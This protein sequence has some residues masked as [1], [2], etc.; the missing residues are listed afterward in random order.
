MVASRASIRQ[1]WP[2]VRCSAPASWAGLALTW[3]VRYS[4]RAWLPLAAGRGGSAGRGAKTSRR[5]VAPGHSYSRMEGSSQPCSRQTAWIWGSP[6]PARRPTPTSRNSSLRPGLRASLTPPA[7][8]LAGSMKKQ[9][10][11]VM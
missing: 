10:G 3:S 4:S 8:A 6:L 9:P 11:L 1:T 7:K 2:E 5:Q